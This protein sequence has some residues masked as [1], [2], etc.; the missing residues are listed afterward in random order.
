MAKL[1]AR[2]E[3]QAKREPGNADLKAL[4]AELLKQEAAFVSHFQENKRN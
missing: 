4:N 1:K 2:R 3:V